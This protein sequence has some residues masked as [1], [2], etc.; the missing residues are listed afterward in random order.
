M[1]AYHA[2]RNMKAEAFGVHSKRHIALLSMPSAYTAPTVCTYVSFCFMHSLEQTHHVSYE[3]Q[4][5]SSCEQILWLNA[6]VATTQY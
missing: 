2:Y 1:A 4:K 5:H 3:S 6:W